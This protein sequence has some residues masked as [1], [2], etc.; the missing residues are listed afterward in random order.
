MQSLRPSGFDFPTNSVVNFLSPISSPSKIP[1]NPASPDQKSA[2]PL[3]STSNPTTTVPDVSFLLYQLDC[4]A[5]FP[6]LKTIKL[7]VP[8]N[9][10]LLTRFYPMFDPFFHVP[11]T[12][13][14]SLIALILDVNIA[15]KTVL[16]PHGEQN[17]PASINIYNTVSHQSSPHAK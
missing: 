3:H 13:N 16:I 5:Q 17:D 7:K 12:S 9:F 6:S 14:F 10:L 2:S 15:V 8:K 11:I 4:S 1:S